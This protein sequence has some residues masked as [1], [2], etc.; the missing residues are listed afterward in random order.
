[1]KETF[2][3]IPKISVNFPDRKARLEEFDVD[4]NL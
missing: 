1:M 2:T 3:I 4:D